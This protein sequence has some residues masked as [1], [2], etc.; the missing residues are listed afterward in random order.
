MELIISRGA[1]S[2]TTPGVVGDLYVDKDTDRVYRCTSI[3]G[4]KWGRMVLAD[5]V[6]PVDKWLFKNESIT[7]T[8]RADIPAPVPGTSYTLV[9]DNGGITSELGPV[10]A[11]EYGN[12]T[13]FTDGIRVAYNYGYW[14]SSYGPVVASVKVNGLDLRF[15]PRSFDYKV[16]LGEDCMAIV[17]PTINGK[18]Y[19]ENTLNKYTYELYRN[20]QRIMTV[21]PTGPRYGFDWHMLFNGGE[22]H[23]VCTVYDCFGAY[24]TTCTSNSRTADPVGV[25]VTLGDDRVARVVVEKGYEELYNSGLEVAY[26]LYY[27]KMCDTVSRGL[28]FTHDFSKEINTGSYHVECTLLHEGVKLITVASDEKYFT[29]PRVQHFVLDEE[30]VVRYNGEL[31]LSKVD[32]YLFRVKANGQTTQLSSASGGVEVDFSNH[33]QASGDGQYYVSCIG[34]GENGQ[35]CIAFE[36]ER[37][38]FGGTSEDEPDKPV[39]PTFKATLSD[40]GIVTVTPD[41]TDNNCVVSYHL[42]RRSDADGNDVEV[43]YAFSQPFTFDFSEYMMEP[44]VYYVECKI[45]QHQGNPN[46]SQVIAKAYTNDVTISNTTNWL[47][48]DEYLT[49]YVNTTLPAPEAGMSY[50]A[51]VDGVE[52]GTAELVYDKLWAGDALMFPD[53]CCIVYKDGWYFFF[54]PPSGCLTDSGTVSIRINGVNEPEEPDTPETPAE[55]WLFKDVSVYELHTVNKEPVEGVSYTLFLNGVESETATAYNDGDGT[56]LYFSEQGIS[57]L[58]MAWNYGDMPDTLIS[59]RING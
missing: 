27:Y 21:G 34:Y 56:A 39:I 23:V 15:E 53:N 35:M 1:P 37:V 7:G 4:D 55:Q 31:A 52:I 45:N 47:F 57:Y 12:V 20:G 14:Q 41:Y 29:P 40:S 19:T 58:W 42:H 48:K 33:I 59:I 10:T 49:T 24:L 8:Q 36:T 50:T 30:G 32:Y 17:S 26:S 13:F 54:D 38:T 51:F 28:E 25:Q 18:T 44:A 2:S 16:E 11:D 6:A 22:Y 43:H 9:V 46:F 5:E 3:S